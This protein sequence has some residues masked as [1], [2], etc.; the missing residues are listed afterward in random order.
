RMGTGSEG[1]FPENAT[2]NLVCDCRRNGKGLCRWVR[3]GNPKIKN[4]ILR[5]FNSHGAARIR[6]LP[7]DEF[8]HEGFVLGKHQRL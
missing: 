7:P 3:E 2:A 5:H 1:S 8:C 4:V 6:G